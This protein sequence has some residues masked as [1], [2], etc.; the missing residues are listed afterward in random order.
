MSPNIPIKSHTDTLA[1][2]AQF[3]FIRKCQDF[4]LWLVGANNTDHLV[5]FGAV[6]I[7][8][9]NLRIPVILPL[10]EFAIAK[11]HKLI[12]VI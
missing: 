11:Q 9:N 1:H 2:Q 8:Q 4:N 12:G 10:G 3:T 6:S 5:V 7:Q